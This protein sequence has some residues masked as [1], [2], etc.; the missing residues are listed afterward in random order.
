MTTPAE[1]GPHASVNWRNFDR[2]CHLATRC[3]VTTALITGKG[4]PTL[5]PDQINRYLLE[6]APHS[7]P[8]IELQTNGIRLATDFAM[9]DYLAGWYHKG[10]TTIALSAVHYDQNRNKTI[11]GTDYDLKSLVDKLHGIGFSVRLSVM[12]AQGYIDSVEEINQLLGHAKFMGIEQVT[13]RNIEAPWN[14]DPDDK[15]AVWVKENQLS[16]DVMA[17]IRA[18]LYA[19][20]TKVL[21]LSYGAEVF[22][23]MGQNVCVSNCLTVNE[24]KDT[25][26]QLIFFPDGHLRYAWQY[27]GAILL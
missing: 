26:R 25:L 9:K 23:M 16:L 7:F 5:Y 1:K 22:D 6:L 2:A 19:K 8:L 14:S 20:G 3:G 11:Y 13:I 27:P 17:G 4:E 15:E 21:E 10:L 12:L 18:Y 24:E